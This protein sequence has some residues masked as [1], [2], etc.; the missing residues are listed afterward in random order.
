[1]NVRKFSLSHYFSLAIVGLLTISCEVH[2]DSYSSLLAS[3]QVR[4]MDLEKAQL[5][6]DSCLGERLDGLLKINYNC[7]SDVSELAEAENSDRTT[8][9]KMMASSLQ[10]DRQTI[11]VQ[12][13][14]KRHPNY[15]KGV[16]REIRLK[17][18]TTTFWN[19]IGEHPDDSN[20]SRV[21]T[22][23]FAKL[24]VT[25]TESAEIV[26]DNLPLYEAFGVVA[27]E[28]DSSGTLWYQVT[29]DYVPKQKPSNWD[30][31]VIGWISEKD[32][33]SWK[34][35]LVM[36]FTNSLSRAPSVFFKTAEDAVAL[37]KADKMVRKQE[38][39]QL[40]S[41]FESGTVDRTSGALAIEPV[42][43]QGQEQ[44]VMYPLLD[45]YEPTSGEL[46]M[47][48]QFARLLEVAAQTRNGENNQGVN[49][50][51]PIDIVFVMDLTSSMQPYL[52]QLMVVIKQF[53]MDSDGRDIR[54]GFVGYKDKDK[55][56]AFTV[57]QF[58]SNVMKPRDF[59]KV[60]SKVKAR[61][62]PVKTD[63]IPEAVMSGVNLA[64][65]S[66][67]WRDNSAKVIILVGDAPGREDVFPV[68]ELRDKSY[69]RNIP[70][71]SLFIDRSKGAPKYAKLGKKQYEDLSSTYEGA[72]GTSREIPHLTVINGGS[73]DDFAQTV[74]SGLKEARDTF[75]SIASQHVQLGEMEEGS[76]AE[77]LFQ[78]ADL[79]LA[80][81]SMPDNAVVGWVSDKV[82]TSSGREALAPMILLNEAELDELEQRVR[83]LKD[84]GELA[85]RGDSGTTLD[86]FDLVSD[87][88]RFTIV[89]PSAVNFRDAFSAP[90]GIN[91]LPY[92]SDIMATTRE[93]FHSM[94]RVQ[95][96]VRAMN[97]K[98]RHY[99]DLK[100]QQGNPDVWKK[101]STGTS[102]RDRVVGVEL[103]QLP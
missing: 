33:I 91:S 48:G 86:F 80:D 43:G 97:N 51:L 58:T 96:F 50:N 69:V 67:Q 6:S 99:E 65:D 2:A 17:D 92:D 54:F 24:Y 38:L 72:Y 89:D 74:A 14:Q 36:R 95:S 3:M 19:G 44:I 56:F 29:E 63:D 64:L 68:K 27:K 47:D 8:L 5:S 22:K 75:D 9:Y 26:R 21:L 81:T 41:D 49:G 98:L 70:I 42:V 45:F 82:M 34:R 7:A 60:L 71:F 85:L 37:M 30:P 76:V 88:T 83:E 10:L 53:A 46:Y 90:L 62:T 73:P 39:D 101:L 103:N 78:Q 1:M 25:P 28:K 15:I 94:D 87:N 66:Q 16:I 35:A 20:I 12:W 23:Q 93:E 13:A 102:E 18:G 84:I 52:E 59:V 32:A 77:L 79:L 11:G 31:E 61:E 57:K 100:R 55:K 4:Q 40:Y